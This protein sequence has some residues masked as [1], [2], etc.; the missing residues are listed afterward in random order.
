[1]PGRIK[2]YL[3]RR[4]GGVV[5]DQGRRARDQGRCCLMTNWRGGITRRASRPAESTMTKAHDL[6]TLLDLTSDEVAFLA[7]LPCRS[8][9]AVV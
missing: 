2:W 4:L 3:R 8:G 6:D 1:V 5:Y 7:D 9:T